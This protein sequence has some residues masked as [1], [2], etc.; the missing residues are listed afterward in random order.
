MSATWPGRSSA[1]GS[2]AA[3]TICCCEDQRAIRERR[4]GLYTRAR[5]DVGGL[6]HDHRRRRSL[7]GRPDDARL[8]RAAKIRRGRRDHRAD[9]RL[10]HAAGT[11]PLLVPYGR[12]YGDPPTAGAHGPTGIRGQHRRRGAIPARAGD[13]T[14]LPPPPTPPIRSRTAPGL[15]A[16]LA[17]AP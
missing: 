14:R 4:A 8:V 16:L 13:V 1:T 7:A 12:K 9:L 10:A 6:A 11:V 15:P 3:R 5:R 17:C 2:G